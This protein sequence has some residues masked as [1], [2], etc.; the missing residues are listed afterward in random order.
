MVARE[1]TLLGPWLQMGQVVGLGEALSL[2]GVL[3]ELY[4]QACC[5]YADRGCEA[6][7]D[8]AWAEC[9]CD[10]GLT[11]ISEPAR[12][13]CPAIEDGSAG[14]FRVGPCGVPWQG[15]RGCVRWRVSRFEER[16]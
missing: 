9:L 1:M 14:L 3:T 16:A 10:D 12:S 5:W 6:A 15:A 8:L 2:T 4:S 7:L 11:E 13:H